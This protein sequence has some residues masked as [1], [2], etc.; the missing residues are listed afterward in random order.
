[1]CPDATAKVHGSCA[2]TLTTLSFVLY[3]A[4]S[5]WLKTVLHRSPSYCVASLGKED[6]LS[7]LWDFTMALKLPEQRQGCWVDTLIHI[8]TFNLYSHSWSHSS[9]LLWPWSSPYFLLAGSA[10]HAMKEGETNA[11]AVAAAKVMHC[12]RLSNHGFKLSE[13]HLDAT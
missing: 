7:C 11:A 2:D 9:N 3:T 12:T 13:F 4:L 10:C 6:P 5:S 8:L 1:M